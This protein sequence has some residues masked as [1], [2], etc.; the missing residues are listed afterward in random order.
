MVVNRV[1]LPVWE[2]NRLQRS[3]L[4]PTVSLEQGM[5]GVFLAKRETPNNKRK[6]PTRSYPPH[7][8]LEVEQGDTRPAECEIYLTKPR[9]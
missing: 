6:Q 7:F 3:T 2:A 9:G 5:G 8:C 1:P 4:S